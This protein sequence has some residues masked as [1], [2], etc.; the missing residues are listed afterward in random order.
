MSPLVIFSQ[1]VPRLARF[2]EHVLGATAAT[3]KSGDIRL[4]T[5]LDEVLVHSISKK[6][7]ANISVQTPPV[8]R[9]GSAL[10]PVFEVQSLSS[11]LKRVETNG[12]VVTN[13]TFRYNGITR[14]DILDPDGN[15]IQ[16][17]DSS[18]EPTRVRDSDS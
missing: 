10:K 14:H 18:A 13:R 1:D 8:P 2:Y 16:L 6:I 9:D 15:V 12:G 3:E 5:D 11:A 7:S 4:V 17:R